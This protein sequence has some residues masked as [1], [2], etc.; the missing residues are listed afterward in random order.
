MK[1]R[2]VACVVFYDKD[3]NIAVQERES[4]SKTGEALGFWGGEIENEETKEK[5]IIR[6]LEEELGYAPKNLKYWGLFSYISQG[7]GPW[8]GYK[9]L[10]HIF[11]SPTTPKLLNVR[12][13]EGDGIKV[14]SLTKAVE[15]EGFPKGSTNFLKG[16]KGKL[17]K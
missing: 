1:E 15:G 14:I 10:Q 3:Y 2:H 9:I 12:V 16:L 13:R 11:L 8:Q 4:I 6:E 5:A 17:P 7:K